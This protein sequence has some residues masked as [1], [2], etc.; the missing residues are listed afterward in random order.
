MGRTICRA[1]SLGH[2]F[3]A[4]CAEPEKTATLTPLELM[5]CADVEDVIAEAKAEARENPV[6]PMAIGVEIYDLIV[7]LY[8]IC[9]S[10]TGDG[11]R[12]TLGVLAEHIPLAIHEVPT[13]TQVFDWIV[14]REWNI[15]DAYVK[16]PQGRKVIDFNNSNLHVVSYS[17]PVEE[18]ISLSELKPRLHS[19]PNHPDWI[20][21]KTTYFT[22][23]WGFCLTHRQ[24]LSLE[25]GTFEVRIDASLEDGSLTYGECYL[26]GESSDEVLISCH[27]CHPSLC[28]DN[29]SGIAVATFL[30][31]ALARQPRRLSYR[32]LF[33]PATIGSI[34]WL[35]RNESRL[36]SIK[37]GL[38]LTCLG[39]EGQLTYKKSRR[40]DAAIDK[41]CQH[42]LHH[43]N[44]RG[45]LDFY[46]YGY[47]ERQYCSPGF[48]LPVGVLMRTPHGQFPQYHTSADDLSFVK[49]WALGDSYARCLDVFSILENNVCYRN[50]NPKCEPQLGRRGL[51]SRCGGRPV[52]N[53]ELQRAILP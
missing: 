1:N 31:K 15:R 18:S 5:D 8:P 27:I 16:D 20:P 17:V 4:C 51:Y 28:N 32:I 19:L 41:A 38:V 9:R 40:G 49:P 34:T 13:G 33:I 47:D 37:H 22:E 53:A 52:D 29:L 43:H 35:S 39:D 44:G 26:E 30:A 23:D 10:I 42:V 50:T 12:Q 36:E 14:P 25:E 6:D 11:V 48:N 46:P 7:E 2:G 24:L 45:V 21:H 3:L